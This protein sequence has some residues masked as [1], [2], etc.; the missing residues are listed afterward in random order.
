[1]AETMPGVPYTPTLAILDGDGAPYTAGVAGTMALYGPD[2]ATVAR[3]TGPLAFFGARGWGT[4]FAGALLA[5]PGTY[6]YRVPTLTTPGGTLL[7]QGGTFRVG[8]IPPGA[9][10][11]RELVVAVATA[12]GDGLVGRGAGGA[13][14]LIDAAR[15]GTGRDDNEWVGSELVLLGPSASLPA[16]NPLRVASFAAATGRFGLAPAVTLAGQYDYL[17][18]NRD[19]AGYPYARVREALDLAI[20]SVPLRERAIDA[21]SL[22]T[23]GARDYPLAPDWYA[24]RAVAVGTWGRDGAWSEVAPGYWEWDAVAGVLRD[25]YG[26]WPTGLPL[27]IEGLVATSP[28][29][30]LGAIVPLP[31]AWVRDSALAELLLTSDRPAD[32]RRAAVLLER[33]R[34]GRPR[35]LVG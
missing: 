4:T 13:G 28:P 9:R 23:T 14:T 8:T 15:G 21:V 27:R 31:W 35:A 18:C 3:G 1:M 24:V 30:D 5:R 20:G 12:L 22:T 26:R 34:R 25:P 19:G 2:D 10:T 17:L 6:R 32:Q 11:L 7:D 33:T 16:V 29:A